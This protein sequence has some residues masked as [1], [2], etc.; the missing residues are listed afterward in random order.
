MGPP[1]PDRRSSSAP[2]APRVSVPAIAPPYS[3]SAVRSSGPGSDLLSWVNANLP[4]QYP[5]A[6]SLPGSFVSGEVIFLLVRAL[7]GIEPNP[8]VPPNAFAPEGGKPGV[9]GLFAMMDLLIDAGVDTVGVSLNDIREGDTESIV[10]LL[11]S[12]KSWHQ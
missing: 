4:A 9:S 6:A 1:R 8:P 10:R 2:D 12:V 3:S 11:K 5:R 7:S